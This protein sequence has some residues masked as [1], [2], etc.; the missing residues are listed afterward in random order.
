MCLLVAPVPKEWEIKDFA[1]LLV[2]AQLWKKMNS[3][4]FF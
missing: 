3:S 4:L 2:S 1:E